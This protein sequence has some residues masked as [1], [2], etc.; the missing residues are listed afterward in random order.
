MEAVLSYETLYFYQTT[1]CQIPEDT[2][3]ACDALE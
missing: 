3:V 2:A 1:R